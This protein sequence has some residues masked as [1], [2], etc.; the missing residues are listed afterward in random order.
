MAKHEKKRGGMQISNNDQYSYDYSGSSKT[1]QDGRGRTGHRTIVR[2]VKV[3][4]VI[5]VSITFY[6]SWIMYY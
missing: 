1:Y 4:D 3:I 5:L 6:V 2:L